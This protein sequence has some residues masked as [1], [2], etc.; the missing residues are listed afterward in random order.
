MLKK[1]FQDENNF[2][3]LNDNVKRGLDLQMSAKVKDG[4]IKLL[5]SNLNLEKKEL[6][7]TMKIVMSPQK[8]K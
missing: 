1:S 5:G 2:T 8:I 3:I 4:T 6:E 7:S